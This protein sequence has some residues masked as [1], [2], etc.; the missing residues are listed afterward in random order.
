[1]K[2]YQ[3]VVYENPENDFAV[4]RVKTDK[5]ISLSAGRYP[6]ISM[7]FKD[8]NEIQQFAEEILTKVD[9]ED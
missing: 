7:H 6:V 4:V 9:N 2:N 8:L 5:L 1:M 3:I